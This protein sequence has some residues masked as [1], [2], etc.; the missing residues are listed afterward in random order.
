M[1]KIIYRKHAIQRM[2]ERAITSNDVK[3]VIEHGEV[4]A[5]YPND[6]PNPSRL[7]LS[8]VENNPIHVVIAESKEELIVITVYR[9]DPRLW[10]DNFRS[11]R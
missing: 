6:T 10:K 5:N 1:K 8:F 4:I 7:L 3:I 9:P 11:K 2:F